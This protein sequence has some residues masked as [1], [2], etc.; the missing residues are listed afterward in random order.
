[1]R[2]DAVLYTISVWLQRVEYPVAPDLTLPHLEFKHVCSFIYLFTF[3]DYPQF[4]SPFLSCL[5]LYHAHTLNAY[6]IDQ[7]P[8]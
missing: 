7:R 4:Q 3:R 5:Y 1:M 2:H 8:R 6:L